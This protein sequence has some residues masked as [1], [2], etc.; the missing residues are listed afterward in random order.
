[1]GRVVMGKM[2]DFDRKNDGKNDGQIG[3]HGKNAGSI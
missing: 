1:M 3:F 2:V